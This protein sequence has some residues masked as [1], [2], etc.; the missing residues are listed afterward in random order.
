V[1][2]RLLALPG[3]V[4]ARLSSG[5]SR[6]LAAFLEAVLAASA[7][8]W[9]ARASLFELAAAV[10][11]IVAAGSVGAGLAWLVA[12]VCLLAKSF[13]ADLRRGGKR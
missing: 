9:L 11:L 8:V 10:C 13:E 5:A 3:R 4:L 2:T 1:V 6:V 7:A 12:G